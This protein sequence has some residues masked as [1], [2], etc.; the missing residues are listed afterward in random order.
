MASFVTRILLFIKKENLLTIFWL[1]C[2]L[3]GCFV[4]GG[5]VSSAI[6]F[7]APFGQKIETV[8]FPILEHC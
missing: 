4:E 1:W 6:F 8:Y 3:K 7:K 5:V 2:V